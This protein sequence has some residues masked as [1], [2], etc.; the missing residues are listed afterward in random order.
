M[1]NGTTL[2]D[3]WSLRLIATEA[4]T[5]HVGSR[6]QVQVR[7]SYRAAENGGELAR[8]RWPNGSAWRASL[9][10]ARIT[11]RVS[12]GA[13]AAGTVVRFPDTP[14]LGV[15]N[16]DG[17]IEISDLVPGPYTVSIVD[18]WLAPIGIAIPTPLKIV[19]AR[20][21]TVDGSIVARTASEFVIDR[22]VADRK[23]SPS[24]SMLLVGRAV[25]PF[26]QPIAGINIKLSAII[27]ATEEKPLSDSY[28]HRRRRRFHVLLEILPSRNDGSGSCATRRLD[29]TRRTRPARRQPH[30]ATTCR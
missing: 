24:D 22:C 21:S 7:T 15:A 13:P 2:I 8:A 23:Y 16:R 12:G 10:T 4:D 17:I 20:D 25:G 11:A 6:E 27:S 26:G 30:R 3:R 18:P 14:Y 5:V 19:A 28:T 9:G 29:L 1:P